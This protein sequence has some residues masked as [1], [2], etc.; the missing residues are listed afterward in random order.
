MAKKQVFDESV[1]SPLEKQA[2]KV[3]SFVQYNKPKKPIGWSF[4]LMGVVLYY[5]FATFKYNREVSPIYLL[6]TGVVVIIAALHWYSTMNRTKTWTRL[7][8]ELSRISRGLVDE[9]KILSETELKDLFI[10]N[11]EKVNKRKTK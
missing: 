7:K 2:R 11:V 10:E 4:I 9:G 8:E 6:I 5:L 1:L 3:M